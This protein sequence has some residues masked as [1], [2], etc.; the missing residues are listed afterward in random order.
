[1]LPD[2]GPSQIIWG[3]VVSAERSSPYGVSTYTLTLLPQP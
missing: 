1:M 2:T 3:E